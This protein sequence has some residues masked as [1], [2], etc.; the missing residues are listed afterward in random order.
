M[1]MLHKILVNS[2][3][4]Q[5]IHSNSWSL[6]EVAAYVSDEMQDSCHLSLQLLCPW[7][8]VFQLPGLHSLELGSQLQ[9]KSFAASP[10]IGLFNC[11]YLKG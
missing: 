8:P 11:V 4:P 6:F 5:G 2:V 10:S 7:F 1:A 9:K 3:P